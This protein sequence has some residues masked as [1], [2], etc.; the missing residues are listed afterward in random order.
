MN[1]F[2]LRVVELDSFTFLANSLKVFSLAD[3]R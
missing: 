2:I 1:H 3:S